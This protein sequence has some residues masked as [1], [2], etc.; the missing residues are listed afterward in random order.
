MGSESAEPDWR[1]VGMQAWKWSAH[2]RSSP[3]ARHL[4][5][6]LQAPVHFRTEYGIDGFRSGIADLIALATLADCE[7]AGMAVCDGSAC[8]ITDLYEILVEFSADGMHRALLWLEPTTE[9]GYVWI[10]GREMTL[11]GRR[12]IGIPSVYWVNDRH[13]ALWLAAPATHPAQ[14][15]N[16]SGSRHRGLLGLWRHDLGCGCGP[17]ARRRMAPR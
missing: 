1:Q 15:Q 5:Y 11:D 16:S 8:F 10:D 2:L 13:F 6:W 14:H 7:A 4:F 12:D 3:I 17:S 9:P